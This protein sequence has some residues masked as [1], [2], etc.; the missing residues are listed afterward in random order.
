M[1]DYRPI[2]E[3]SPARVLALAPEP[4]YRILAASDAYLED[5]MTTRDIVS[6][7]LFDVFPDNP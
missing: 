3:Q 5:T 7:P 4:G 1:F 2:F 6:L